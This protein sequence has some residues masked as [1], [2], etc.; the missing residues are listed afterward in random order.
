MSKVIKVE[1]EDET[2]IYLKQLKAGE[3]EVIDD[4][5]SVNKKGHYIVL[6]MYCREDG[7]QIYKNIDEVREKCDDDLWYF[8]VNYSYD[9]RTSKKKIDSP[10]KK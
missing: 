6:Y 3:R 7:K 10:E 4:Q 5:E 9:M 1:F 2:H 8:I